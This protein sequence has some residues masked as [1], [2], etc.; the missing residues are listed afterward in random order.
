MVALAL[1]CAKADTVSQRVPEALVIGAD[2]VLAFEGELFDKPSSLAAA[3]MQLE[4]LRGATHRLLSGVSLARAGQTVWRHLEAA[5]LTMRAFSP[6]AP[7]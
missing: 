3:R 1:A 2:Q 4:R 5:T 6:A 7:R